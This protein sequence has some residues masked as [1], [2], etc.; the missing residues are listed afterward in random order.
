MP[1]KPYRLCP[2]CQQ[3]VQGPCTQCNKANERQ[4]DQ[5]RGSAASRGYDHRWSEYSKGYR[6][7]HPLCARCEAKGLVVPTAVVGH[8][9]PANRFP[10]LFWDEA[11]HVPLCRAC[12]AQQEREDAKQYPLGHHPLFMG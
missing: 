2:K 3:V 10:D 5:Y 4:H 7:N 11:N 8:I 1:S 9:K 12:N 6:A